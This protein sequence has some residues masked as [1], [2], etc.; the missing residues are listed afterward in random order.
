MQQQRRR[1]FAII[2]LET[3]HTHTDIVPAGSRACAASREGR[4]L[5]SG[6]SFRWGAFVHSRSSCD[7]AASQKRLLQ[8]GCP[9]TLGY[10]THFCPLRRSSE[11]SDR[12]TRCFACVDRM[13]TSPG[14]Q[15]IKRS[16]TFSVAPLL[17]A[18][19]IC[20][21]QWR[22]RASRHR[23]ALS[24]GGGGGRCASRLTTSHHRLSSRHGGVGDVFV[25]RRCDW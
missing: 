24:R 17:Q 14:S 10:V 15:N 8:G 22:L 19:A 18:F 7:S 23:Q 20:G 16:R 13:A 4:W 25:S 21:G 2:S 12:G 9:Q 6:S 1:K 5:R 11:V 3:P